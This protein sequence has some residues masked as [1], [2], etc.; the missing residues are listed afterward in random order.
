MTTTAAHELKCLDA[1][2]PKGVRM[3]RHWVCTCGAWSAFGFDSSVF[4]GHRAHR[5]EA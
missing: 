2:L 3:E 4:K 1:D 5:K